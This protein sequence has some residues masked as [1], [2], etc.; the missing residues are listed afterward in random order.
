MIVSS[1][2]LKKVRSVFNLNIYEAKVWIALLS[3]GI[4]PAGE[5]SAI[6]GVP[7]SRSYDVLESLEKKGFVIMKIGKPIKYIA[8]KPEEV[9]KRMQKRL[10]EKTEEQLRVLE[11]IKTKD[12]YKQI[13][14]LYK[15]GIE[16][17][18]PTE[19]SGSIKGR[20]ALYDH[21]KSII[22]G[23]EKRVTI[24]TTATEAIRKAEQLKSSLKNAKERG[25]KIRIA[26]PEVKD[27]RISELKDIAEVRKL[28]GNSA[29]FVVVDGKHV[30]FMVNSDEEVH[31]AYD[32]GI[33]VKT[34]YF[35]SALEQLFEANWQ[36]L[37]RI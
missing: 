13:E 22:D 34:P 37:E 20:K 35:A 19:L 36:K 15:Q 27:E 1:E 31:D 29:R 33:W 16:K 10:Q 25:I 7:R 17:I 23:A 2:F 9:V 32:V 6:S 3:R 5:L 12:I 18:D 14:L 28:D 21:L 8:V 4:A 11:E 24:V 26:V 30:V